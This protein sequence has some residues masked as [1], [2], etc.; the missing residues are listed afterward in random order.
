[1]KRAISCTLRVAALVAVAAIPL[2][3]SAASVT[4]TFSTPG[5]SPSGGKPVVTVHAQSESGT[6]AEATLP[7]A[8]G[9]TMALAPGLWEL[10]PTAPGFWSQPSTVRVAGT[11]TA[12]TLTLFPA[13]TLRGAIDTAAKTPRTLTIHFQPT[14]SDSPS[15]LPASWVEC[16]V[17]SKR[18]KC[19]VPAGVLDL[20]IRAPGFVSL[21][22]WNQRLTGTEGHDL[23][24]LPLR[25][26]SSLSGS[27]SFAERIVK[28]PKINVAVWQEAS[29]PQ[30]PDR[31]DRDRLTRQTAT[32]NT[33][34]FFDL[35]VAPGSYTIQATAGDLISEPREVRVI[36]GRESMLRDP[37]VL[38]RPRTF[39][40]QVTPPVD[41]LKKQWSAVLQKL[42]RNRV[43]ENEVSGTIPPSG[44]W[45]KTSL[46]PGRY[47][48]SIRRTPNDVWFSEEFVLTGDDTRDVKLNLGPVKGRSRSPAS[49]CRGRSGS[50]AITASR[51]FRSSRTKTARSPCCCRCRSTI[52]G[53]RSP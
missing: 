2:A 26:G 53:A 19:D 17:S 40:L 45:E 21:Y 12:T 34:G 6:T 7:L 33:R 8:K 52:C 23:G 35:T 30:T 13:V 25:R 5:A 37:L 47:L 27:V 50:A 38:E 24:T 3:A 18:W 46:T 14:P 1:M 44:R 29:L 39:A 9:G 16:P 4:V 51:A 48:L 32:P 20:A 42:D 15:P 41:P 31:K 49:R 10:S 43:V 36:D 22:R 11:P 28:P